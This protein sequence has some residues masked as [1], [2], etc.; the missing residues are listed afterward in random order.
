MISASGFPRP[1]DLRYSPIALA[2]LPMPHITVQ[3]VELPNY[4]QRLRGLGQAMEDLNTAMSVAAQ[5][6]RVQY[7]HA[8]MDYAAGV[9]RDPNQASKKR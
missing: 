3:A 6:R 9:G 7:A 1:A 4:S 8:A 2:R 5:Y